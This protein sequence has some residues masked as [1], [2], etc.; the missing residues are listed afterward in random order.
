MKKFLR[1]LIVLFLKA[2]S[3]LP[4]WIL[5]VKS[6]VF[7]FLLFYVVRYRKKVVYTNLRNAFPE[8]TENEI[9]QIARK[10]YHH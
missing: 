6:D 2:Y 5:Y 3:H 4:F 10:F 9:D 8:K 1:N 7:Y